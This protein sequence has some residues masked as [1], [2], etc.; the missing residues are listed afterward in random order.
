MIYYEMKMKPFISL[1]SKQPRLYACLALATATFAVYCPILF[2]NFLFYWDD[3][4]V[5]MN[6]YTES[7]LGLANIWAIFSEYYHGQYAPLNEMTYLLLYSVFGYNPFWFH[8]TSMLM[9]IICVCLVFH[10]VLRLLILYGDNAGAKSL[11]IAFFTA[12]IFAIHPM[13]VESVAWMSA[14]KVLVYALFYLLA[15]NMFISLL[16]KRKTRYYIYT[17]LLFICSF[18]G[19]EQ[20]VSFPVWMALVMLMLNSKIKLNKLNILWI[21]LPFFLLSLFFGYVTMMSQAVTGGGILSN[22]ATYPLWQRFIFG[23]YSLFEYLFKCIF[24]FK[25]SYLYPFPS[26]IGGRLPS[27]LFVYPSLLAVGVFCLW[28]YLKRPA[29]MYGLLFFVINIA[30]ALH[31]IPL[32]RFAIIADRYVYI[33]SIGMAFII[34]CGIVTFWQRIKVRKLFVAGISAY[35]LFL[36]AYAHTRTYVWHDTDSLKKEIRELI[37]QREDYLKRFTK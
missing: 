1:I 6:R 15:T 7:G 9:H 14:S 29:I 25:L 36:G 33:S 31:I 37:Q 3:Q 17:L 26:V 2:N 28:K 20:A 24:P 23:C 30:V 5:V 34:A 32:S 12:L 8:L 35:L 16:A 22:A 13:N 27:W 10:I 11:P 19:K 18:F 4:W 21:S